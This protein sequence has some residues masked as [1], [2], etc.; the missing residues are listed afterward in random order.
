MNCCGFNGLDQAF[1]N[2]ER[3]SS[4]LKV[5]LPVEGL[6]PLK[7][8]FHPR[9]TLDSIQCFQQSSVITMTD[10]KKKI[11]MQTKKQKSINF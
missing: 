9:E 8:F 7:S 10:L 3:T 11:L 1:L 5:P 4:S 6:I 2:S